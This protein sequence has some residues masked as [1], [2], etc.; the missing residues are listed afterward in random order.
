LDAGETFHGTS[1]HF[2]TEELDGGPVIAQAR[3]TVKPG[4]T[5][6]ALNQRV[7]ALEHRMYP[8]VIGWYAEGRLKMVGDSVQMDGDILAAPIVKDEAEWLRS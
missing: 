5:A 6:E 7:Q 2:V 4:D 1:V 3:L 8:R